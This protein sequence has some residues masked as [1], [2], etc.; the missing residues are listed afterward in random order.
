MKPLAK[1]LVT[2]ILVSMACAAAFAGD[3][4]NVNVTL[5]RNFTVNGA[6]LKAGEYKVVVERN[7]ADAKVTFLNEKKAVA[8]A[9]GKFA[10]AKELGFGFAVI[11]EGAVITGVQGD[12]LKGK[13][14]L[15]PGSA[16]AAGN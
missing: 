8:S 4:Q 6:Q 12:K 7:G 2:V 3:T 1:V 9:S 15:A 5:S 16:T 11:S 10:E 14:E 13:I